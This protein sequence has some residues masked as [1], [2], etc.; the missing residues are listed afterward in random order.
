MDSGKLFTIDAN[1]R[2]ETNENNKKSINNNNNDNLMWYFIY[3]WG[4]I[5]KFVY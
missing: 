4:N 1:Q 2:G 5:S 3:K